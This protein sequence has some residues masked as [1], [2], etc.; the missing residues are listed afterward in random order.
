MILR[1]LLTLLIAHSSFCLI[2][3]LMIIRESKSR[4]YGFIINTISVAMSTMTHLF[5]L[6]SGVLI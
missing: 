1:D 3:A 6:R 4:D 2:A 5:F